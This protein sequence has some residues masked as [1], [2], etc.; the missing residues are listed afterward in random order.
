MRR[1]AGCKKKCRG[2]VGKCLTCPYNGNTKEKTMNIDNEELEQV[3][4]NTTELSLLLLPHS[5]LGKVTRGEALA[6]YCA[7]LPKLEKKEG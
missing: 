7:T 3:I 6:M 5:L 4:W 2:Q 1:A